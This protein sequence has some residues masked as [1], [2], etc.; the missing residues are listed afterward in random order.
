MPRTHIKTKLDNGMQVLLKEIHTTPLISL[1]L[2]FRVGSRDESA[3]FTGISHLVEHMQFKGTPKFPAA[4]IDKAVARE[5]G[6]RNAFTYLDWTT[7]FETMP[8]NKID[9][10]L[11][12][13][14]DRMC[15]SVFDPKEFAS[16]RTVVISEREGSENEPMFR[17]AEAVQHAAFRVH[18][19]HHEVI[20]DMA[21]LRS[22]QR[23]DLFRHYRTYYIPNNAV[24]SIAG[25]FDARAML[26]RIRRLFGRI[27]P[28]AP[29]PRL[30]RPEPPAAGERR[31]TVE[32]PGQTS[33]IQVA[34]RFPPA[35]HPDFFALSVLDSLLAGPS[36]LNMFGGGG[37]SNKTSRL[38]RALVDRQF[39]VGLAGGASPTI[40]PSLYT[41]SLTVHPKRQSAEAL[42]ALDQ[43]LARLRSGPIAAAE[44]RRAIKQARANFAYGSENITN[45]AFWLG[46]A[47]MFADYRWFESYLPAMAAVKVSDVRRVAEEYLSPS[48]RVVGTYLPRGA[49]R[50]NA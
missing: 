11:E 20:G 9:L 32:G 16:E 15:N 13:E 14:A 8:A 31:V 37:I 34:Y 41:I 42:E 25:D 26:S 35:G 7:Y 24:L 50:Q 17:L 1:W 47:E 10:A 45:Q 46:Y 36:N 3:P 2:W 44:I 28:G 33:Y 43:E 4:K 29:P 6:T 48:A 49:E 18:P 5:G 30:H 27:S 38:Y 40:D 21:D 12:L 39:A 19:Y 22:M 23:D